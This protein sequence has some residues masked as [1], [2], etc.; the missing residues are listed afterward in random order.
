MYYNHGPGQLLM[1]PWDL[2]PMAYIN[3]ALSLIVI[4]VGVYY[5]I[6]GR[7]LDRPM[8]WVNTL[9]GL[10][11]LGAYL[12]IIVD[13]FF[14]DILTPQEVTL[15]AIRPAL[16]VLLVTKLANMIRMGRRDEK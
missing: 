14:I 4:A 2:N 1:S 15:Y 13:A 11:V 10:W 3:T 9:A 5:A 8:M 12:T 6:W 16:F 7:K